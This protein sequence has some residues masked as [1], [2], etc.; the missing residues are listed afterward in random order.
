L[1]LPWLIKKQTADNAR[2]MGLQDR[3]LIKRGL[4]ADLNIIDH[5]ALC[6][7]RPQMRYDLP[8]GGK[9]LF[10]GAKGYVATIVSGVPVMRYDQPTGAR[11]GR[12]IRGPRG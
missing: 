3:G 6:L 1:P 10:Q 5:S 11:P 12:L 7:P 9:R 2:H 8:A 4:K